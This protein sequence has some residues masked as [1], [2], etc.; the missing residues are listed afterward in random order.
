MIGNPATFQMRV[1]TLDCFDFEIHYP[2]VCPKCGASTELENS[3][4]IHCEEC[5]WELP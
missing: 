3:G 4:C 5:D 1:E 2:K